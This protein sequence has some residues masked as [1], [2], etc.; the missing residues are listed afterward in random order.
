MCGQRGWGKGTALRLCIVWEHHRAPPR[1]DALCMA[2][3]EVISP[4]LKPSQPHQVGFILP[5]APQEQPWLT[6][7]CEGKAS[8]AFMSRPWW[9]GKRTSWRQMLEAQESY[10]TGRK[11]GVRSIPYLLRHYLIPAGHG[12]EGAEDDVQGHQFWNW[13]S[14]ILVLYCEFYNILLIIQAPRIID[15]E[16]LSFCFS[17]SFFFSLFLF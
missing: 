8:R 4:T 13:Y 5:S 9:Q 6:H 16:V 14:L 2:W 17:I 1:E 15:I 10:K 11:G 7:P 12:M 3:W